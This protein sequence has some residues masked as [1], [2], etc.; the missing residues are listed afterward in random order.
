ME[1]LAGGTPTFR[2]FAIE[3]EGAAAYL[4][5]SPPHKEFTKGAR[6]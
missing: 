6:I 1:K 2:N 5:F 3:S 4:E